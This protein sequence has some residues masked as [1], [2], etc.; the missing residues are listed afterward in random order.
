MQMNK[1]KKQTGIVVM[2]IPF[3]SQSVRARRW[4]S[5][6]LAVMIACLT[7]FVLAAQER[8]DRAPKKAEI[9]V[10][11]LRPLLEFDALQANTAN[12]TGHTSGSEDFEA[13]LLATATETVTSRKFT[14][15]TPEV[16]Q[17]TTAEDRPKQLQPLVSRLARGI[18]NE[19]ARAILNDLATVT[20]NSAV[21]VQFMRIKT[22]PSGSWNPWTGQITSGMSSTVLQ[23]SLISC[24][25]GQVLWKNESVTRKVYRSNDPNF[26]KWL[27]TV[28]QTLQRQSN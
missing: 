26:A 22:G 15:V 14:A 1:R 7:P 12:R 13:K 18:V 3:R 28:Y 8:P 4:P 11:V 24:Q 23:V 2:Q 27:A 16:L 17:N 25:T 6:L 19:E 20:G 5:L 10:V 21:L 9:K